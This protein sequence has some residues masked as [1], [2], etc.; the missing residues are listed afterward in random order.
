VEA[1]FPRQLSNDERAVLDFLLSGEFPGVEALQ[2]QARHATVTHACVC[3]CP[4][5]NIGVDK[6]RAVRAETD[7]TRPVDVEAHALSDDP[8]FELLLFTDDGWLSYMELVWYGDDPPSTLP[9][10][11]S[12]HPPKPET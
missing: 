7:P 4:S 10:P 2:A 11:T 9:P 12:F 8:Y 3:G 1:Q 5:F 6:T